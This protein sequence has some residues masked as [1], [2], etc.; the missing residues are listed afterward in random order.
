MERQDGE[1]ERPCM[2]MH[3]EKEFHSSFNDG[4]VPKTKGLFQSQ[5][6]S[7]GSVN[8][9]PTEQSSGA[10]K[11]PFNLCK[12]R[13][14]KLPKPRSPINVERPNK[15]LRSE[16]DGP[17]SSFCFPAGMVPSSIPLANL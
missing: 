12:D 11:K 13:H 9:G 10:R 4:G 7:V 3:G 17:P 1:V 8:V 2:R 6:P 15:C 14:K 5:N 16:L